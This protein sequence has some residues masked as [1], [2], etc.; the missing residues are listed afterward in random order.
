[1]KLISKTTSAVITETFEIEL[2][3][4]NTVY[5]IDYLNESGKVIDTVFRD[6]DGNDL[7]DD[8]GLYDAILEFLEMQLWIT[9]LQKSCKKIWIALI[10][11]LNLSIIKKGIVPQNQKKREMK[12]VE[13]VAQLEAAKTLSSQ[14]DI[15]KVIALIQQ[16][17]AE[18]VESKTFLLN[19]ESFDKVMDIVENAIGNLR[20]RDIV[21]F[22][23]AEFELNYNNTI[24]LVDVRI[25]T[26]SIVN[27]IREELENIFE[28]TAD[29]DASDDSSEDQ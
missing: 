9:F 14:V 16:L 7:S 22:D 13:L 3:A 28:E 2:T 11:F 21:D 8:P 24:E 6:E 20:T 12:K 18:Q 4:G 19:E 26:D 10:N 5:V 1:M 29:E 27:N 17:E 25:D 15:D 23:D